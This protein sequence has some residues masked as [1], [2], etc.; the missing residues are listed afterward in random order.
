MRISQ[1]GTGVAGRVGLTTPEG[2]SPADHL[3]QCGDPSHH[4]GAGIAAA[5][6]SWRWSARAAEPGHAGGLH[7]RAEPRRAWF[8]EALPGGPEHRPGYRARGLTGAT[9]IPGRDP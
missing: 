5:A 1:F 7:H 8:G 2:R 4:S 3:H 9:S 6:A